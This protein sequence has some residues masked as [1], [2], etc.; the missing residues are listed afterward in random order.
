M[1]RNNSKK[2]ICENPNC[3]TTYLEKYDITCEQPN[4]KKTKTYKL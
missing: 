3:I 1:K 2:I 4:N